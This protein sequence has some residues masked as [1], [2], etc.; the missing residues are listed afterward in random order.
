MQT[1]GRLQQIS[2]NSGVACDARIL[3][4]NSRVEGTL[5]RKRTRR[6]GNHEVDTGAIYLID[7]VG[8][9][10]NNRD[11][12]LSC[13][14]SSLGHADRSLPGS[15]LVV[16]VALSGDDQIGMSRRFIKPNKVEHRLDTR[17]HARAQREKRGACAT[18]ST[19]TGNRHERARTSARLAHLQGATIVRITRLREKPAVADQIGICQTE[20]IGRSAL[21]A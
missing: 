19:R 14:F 10:S 17:G 7:V 9:T 13:R 11:Y 1:T 15:R 16:Q 8:P 20:G 3:A 12:R 6:K 4:S 21:R 2:A 18:G 5:Q